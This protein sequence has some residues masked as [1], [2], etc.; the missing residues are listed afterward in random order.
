MME[1]FFQLP[2]SQ[3]PVQVIYADQSTKT[4]A[5][6]AVPP[7]SSWV[8]KFNSI[9]DV[10]KEGS[11][12]YVTGIIVYAVVLN[13]T[14]GSFTGDH[15]WYRFF[16]GNRVT[17]GIEVQYFKQPLDPESITISSVTNTDGFSVVSVEP[18]VPVTMT[19]WGSKAEIQVTLL[20]PP[21]GYSG[22][23]H[24]VVGFGSST[25]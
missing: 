1:L 12:N 25:T 17:V 6:I 18:S 21:Q 14:Y 10:T 19:G 15:I 7:V 11:G 20:T 13:T 23:V 24:F 22:G 16:T 9:N 3:K 4:K 2:K 5:A 8:S